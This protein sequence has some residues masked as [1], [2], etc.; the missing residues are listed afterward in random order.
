MPISSYDRD[1]TRVKGASDDTL[2]GNVGDRLKID[3]SSEISSGN[4]TV[5]TLSGGAT[6]TGSW[7]EIL[8]FVHVSVL[9]KAD[10]PSAASGVKIEWSADGSTVHA[11]DLF[12]H[13]GTHGDQWTFGIT[14]R[15]AR[16]RY[17]NG[18]SPQ[19]SFV[20]QTILH[21]TPSKPSSHRIDDAVDADDDAELVKAVL[22]VKT[23]NGDYLNVPGDDDGNL[24]I[25]ALPGFGADFAFGDVQTS[26]TATVPVRR[27][28]YTK[29][30][31]N[32]QRSIVSSSANDTAAGTG[33]RTVRITYL[34]DAGNGPSTETVTLNGTTP[35]NT[36]SST[37]CFI[38]SIEVLTAGSTGN[39]VGIL[40]LKAAT[41]GGGATIGTIA[42]TDNQTF[43]AHHY[44][45]VGEIANIT[46][47]SVS[48]SGTTVGSG[49]VFFFKAIAIGVAGAVDTQVSDSHRLYG[50]S[51]TTPRSYI[52]P[53]KIPGPSR[54]VVYVTPETSSSTVYRASLDFFQP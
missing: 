24:V 52:S 9:L 4:S 38:E 44:V 8:E 41:G 23:P 36:V 48:H 49:G 45:P 3:A 14:S 27:T 11:D 42:A 50:Q 54:I 13:A 25:T 31:S 29:Q 19:S 40:S 26:A 32:A 10:V 15:Y 43:W 28:T 39:N 16:V 53:V 22:T 5:A 21:R 18:A 6:F 17:I 51:S 37:I 2:I 20:L 47:L 46:G 12:T 35:V 33:A 1:D 30:T 7:V 34:D